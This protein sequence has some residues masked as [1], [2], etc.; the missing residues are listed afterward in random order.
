MPT[1]FHE[2]SQKNSENSCYHCGLDIPKNVNLSVKILGKDQ[3]MCCYGCQAVAQSIVESGLENYYLQRDALPNSPRTATPDILQDLTLFNQENFQQSFVKKFDE[4]QNQ[5]QNQNQTNQKIIKKE[6]SLILEGITCAACVWLNEQHLSK[7]PGVL[8]VNINYATKRARIIWDDAQIKLSQILQAVQNIGYQA[9]PYDPSK[10]EEINKKERRSALWRLWVAGFGMAQAMMY[11]IPMYLANGEMES[12]ILNLMRWA[13]LILTLPVIFYSA[14]PFF[15]NAWKDIKIK[16]LGMDVPISLGILVAFFASCSATFFND[17][18]GEVY[19][20]SVSMFI[21]FLL[22]GRYL[23]MMARQ[24]AVA[25]CESFSKLVPTFSTRILNYFSEKSAE[26]RNLQRCMT[27]ELSV[28]DVVLV[29]PGESIPADGEILEGKSSADESLLTGESRPIAKNVGDLVV[30]GSVNGESPLI[31]KIKAVG[32][33]TRLSE[34]VALMEQAAAEKPKSVEVADKIAAYFVSALLLIAAITFYYWHF[35]NASPEAIWILVSV[36]VVTCPCALSLATPIALTVAAGSLAKSGVLMTHSHAVETLASATHFVFDKTGTLTLGEM[37]LLNIHSLSAAADKS[38]CLQLAASLEQN[39]EHSIAKAVMQSV[40]NTNTNT[41]TEKNNLF[42]VENLQNQAGEGISGNIK[43]FHENSK[44]F[45]GKPEVLINKLKLN[46][47]IPNNVNKQN[48]L[49]LL[50]TET[51]PLA[52]FEFGDQ[53]RPDAEQVIQFL[54]QSPQ[55]KQV[56][57]LSGDSQNVAEVVGKNLHIKAKNIIANATPQDKY[58][59]I[60]NLQNQSSKNII[61]MCGDG[62]NDAPVLAK[63][64]VSL[65]LENATSL[66]KTQAD[67]ILL[68]ENKTPLVNLKSAVLLCQKTFKI[69]HQN[70]LWAVFY[71]LIALPLAISGNVTPWQAGIGMSVSSLLVV[72]NSLRL[73]KVN[74]IVNKKVN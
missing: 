34:I 19:F 32:K 70:L 64:Q 17:G 8:Q 53:I 11:A 44:I 47:D 68:N 22:G 4:N 23:E 69:I 16:R 9:F 50:T 67:F 28:D 31:I 55:N 6:T 7:Q 45:F 46:F 42:L 21:F 5:N 30:G 62:I 12:D 48:T 15:Q 71:N 36:L 56:I 35:L 49:V 73:Q 51:T 33:Q 25:V 74:K 3:Q 26:N 52:I 40:E 59:C 57:L 38:L 65:V 10:H 66:A 14:M 63:S 24:K 2:I 13:S 37:K 29:K 60:E 39:S 54:Q 27:S 61:A 41:N 72:L 18:S 58:K 20:D 43:N 1:N